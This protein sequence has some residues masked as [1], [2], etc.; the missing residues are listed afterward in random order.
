M[1]LLK[2]SGP[3]YVPKVTR[4]PPSTPSSRTLRSR[5]CARCCRSL[6]SFR[7]SRSAL[8]SRLGSNAASRSELAPMPRKERSGLLPRPLREF[9]YT[10]LPDLA[11]REDSSRPDALG[12]VAWRLLDGRPGPRDEAGR[13]SF[14]WL[15]PIALACACGC[16]GGCGWGRG[17]AGAAGAEEATEQISK[18]G[19]ISAVQARGIL[20]DLLAGASERRSRMREIARV[21]RTW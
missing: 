6:S 20:P 3:V 9:P 8:V 1:G 19:R 2:S 5:S 7:A 13:D 21:T 11:C 17:E 12:E 16:A 18:G 14:A 4:K 15:F 10:P